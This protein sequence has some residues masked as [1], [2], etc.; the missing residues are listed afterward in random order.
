MSFFK[1]IKKYYYLCKK[2]LYVKFLKQNNN[3]IE[4]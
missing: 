4:N 2:I 3:K 1:N